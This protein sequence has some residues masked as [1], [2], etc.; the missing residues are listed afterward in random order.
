MQWTGKPAG[1]DILSVCQSIILGQ[2]K[3]PMHPSPLENTDVKKCRLTPCPKSVARTSAPAS[4]Q[5]V[6]ILPKNPTVQQLKKRFDRHIKADFGDNTS[7][8]VPQLIITNRWES[9]KRTKTVREEN[10][11]CGGQFHQNY[12]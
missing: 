4:C 1:G 5:V 8:K 9:T 11:I 6:L 12:T 2:C 7:D 10:W 3:K